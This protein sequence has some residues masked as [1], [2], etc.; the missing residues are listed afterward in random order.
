[1]KKKDTTMPDGSRPNTGLRENK[2]PLLA[3]QRSSFKTLPG[4]RCTL[5]RP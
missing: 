3:N 5:N 4:K 1:M 2:T